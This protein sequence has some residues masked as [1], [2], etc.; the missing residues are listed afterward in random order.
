MLGILVSTVSSICRRFSHV[1]PWVYKKSRGVG[2]FGSND[3]HR[4]RMFK[5]KAR[6]QEGDN[7]G[8]P[9]TVLHSSQ[10]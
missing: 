6:S 8:L 4:I 10:L 2:N 3:F 7:A 1:E 9:S 5:A